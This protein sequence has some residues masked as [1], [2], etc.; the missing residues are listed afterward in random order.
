M[1]NYVSDGNIK[2]MEGKELK[3][4]RAKHNLTQLELAHYL[5]VERVTVARWEVAIRAIPPFLFLALE[6]IEDRLMKGGGKVTA[7]TRKTKSK[8]KE[9]KKNGMPLSK[10]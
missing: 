4:W 10:R 3:N 7:K 1:T 6:A 2:D 8:R 9:V 5:H